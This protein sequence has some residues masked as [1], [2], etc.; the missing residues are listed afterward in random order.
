MSIRHYTPRRRLIG[1]SDRAKI[2]LSL[3]IALYI[4]LNISY[5]LVHGSVLDAITIATIYCGAL[6]ML[7]HADL[8]YGRVYAGRFFFIVLFGG[9]LIE[10]MGVHTTWPFGV[11]EYDRSLGVALFGVPILVP[12]AWILMCH[13]VLVVARKIAPRWVFLYGGVLLATWDYF[14][15]PQMVDAGRWSWSD[16]TSSLPGTPDIPLSNFFGWMLAGCAL[17]GLL[18][19]ALPHD[20]KKE[21]LSNKYVTVFLTWVLFSAVVG[22]LFFFDRPL[23]GVISLLTFGALLAPYLFKTWLGEN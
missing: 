11:Y 1:V 15:D 9:Y 13:P 18:N 5:P 12:F 20:S 22:N 16:I 14:L 17:M 2:L 21:G 19:V 8:A 10:L 23:V 4:G 6:A 7:M 3:S